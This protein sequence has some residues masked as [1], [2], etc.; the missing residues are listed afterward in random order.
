[1]GQTCTPGGAIPTLGLSGQAAV[2]PPGTYTSTYRVVGNLLLTNGAYT[3]QGATFYVD[4]VASKTP[5]RQVSGCTITLGANASLVLDGATLTASGS[6]TGCPMWRGLVLN[7]QSQGPGG[8]YRLIMRNNST[9]SQ[10]L[11]GIDVD[12]SGNGATGYT[13]TSNYWLDNSTFANNLTHVRDVTYHPSTQPSLITNC[14]FSSDPAQMHFPYEENPA[15]GVKCY[16]YQALLLLPT[17]VVP[18]P[19]GNLPSNA[20][21]VRNNTFNQAVYGIVNNQYDRAAVLIQGNYLNKIFQ[22]GIWTV[23]TYSNQGTS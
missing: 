1:M 21:E 2:L 13:G 7:H 12:D 19:R 14:T 9:I 16:T 4:G 18:T 22:T 11:C 17:G 15:T 3:F 23:N 20:I 5:Q 10:A 8:T 6:T